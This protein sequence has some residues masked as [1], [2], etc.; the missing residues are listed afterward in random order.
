LIRGVRDLGIET[1]VLDD[2]MRGASAA[3]STLPNVTVSQLARA[4]F[5]EARR[6]GITPS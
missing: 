1:I 4:A 5:S 6:A 2:V 3:L